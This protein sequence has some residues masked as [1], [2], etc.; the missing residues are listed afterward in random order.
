M[1]FW[2]GEFILFIVIPKLLASLKSY[3]SMAKFLS[4][5]AV[6]KYFYLSSWSFFLCSSNNFWCSSSSFLLMSSSSYNLFFLSAVFYLSN[7]SFS[8][9]NLSESCWDL[10]LYSSS[11][12][13][14][15]C[16]SLILFYLAYSAIW[17]S[18]WVFCFK[19][20]NSSSACFLCSSSFFISFSWFSCLSFSSW[21]I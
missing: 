17:A 15:S 8:F 12:E 21:A 1:S 20:L 5:S 18:S 19:S 13:S 6:Y 11:F 16:C 9:F 4:F 2:S 7:S 10:I 14:I 3:P